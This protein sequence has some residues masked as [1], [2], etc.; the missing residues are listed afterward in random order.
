MVCDAF[1]DD[2]EKRGR[3]INP[4]HMRVRG[5][6]PEANERIEDQIEKGWLYPDDAE[7]YFGWVNKNNTKLP[8]E[9][10]CDILRA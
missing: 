7:K 8:D 4:A 6:E 5:W 3:C 10:N 1:E 9:F 2:P